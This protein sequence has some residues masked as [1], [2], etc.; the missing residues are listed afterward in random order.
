MCGTRSCRS[1]EA[2]FFFY[3][4]LNK[5]FFLSYSFVIKYSFIIIYD[6]ILHAVAH[7]FRKLEGKL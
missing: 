1:T 2:F 4:F 3:A 7:C 5:F 6:I